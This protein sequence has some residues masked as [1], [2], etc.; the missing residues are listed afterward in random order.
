MAEDESEKPI[1]GKVAI[2][3][4]ASRG[5]GRY[6]AQLLWNAGAHLVL[7]ARSEGDLN[8]LRDELLVSHKSDREARVLGRDLGEAGAAQ[9]I[10][11]TAIEQF[12]T[13]DILINNAAILGPVGD[14]QENSWEEWRKTLQV[15]LLAPVELCREVIPWMTRKKQGKIVNLSGGGATS[16]WPR[17]TAYGT[18]K[19]GLVRFTETLAH[20]VAAMNIH[21]NSV[22]PGLMKTE[23]LRTAMEGSGQS[24]RWG[25]D[26][27]SSKSAD[28]DEDI[29]KAAQLCV[30]LASPV[31]DGI[32]GK[33]ISAVWDNWKS[34]PSKLS[35]LKNSDIYTLRRI[36]PR[37]RGESWS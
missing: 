12:G 7:V 31:S 11:A 2:V 15:N 22:A 3:T 9:E 24:A 13:V 1:A 10:V 25:K 36:V 30:F 14:L 6:V 17:F 33:L 23:M 29:H 35:V 19:A 26:Q 32:S 8:T 28:V 34:L 18:A 21:V 16:P 37:D 5:L 20:E 4:G 27:S